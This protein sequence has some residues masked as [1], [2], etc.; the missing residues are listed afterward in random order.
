MRTSSTDPARQSASQ[1]DNVML[2]T[3]AGYVVVALMIGQ[4]YGQFGVA[5]AVASALAIIAGAAHTLARGTLL[6]RLTLATCSMALVALHIHLGGG[7]IE[8]HFGVFVTLALL[9][10]YR[11]WRPILMAAGVIAVQHV[12]FDRLQAAGWAV[13]CTPEADFLKIVLH[14]AYVV[15]QSGVEVLIA[16]RL[17]RAEQQGMELGQIVSELRRDDRIALDISN[18]PAS[19]QT[20]QRLK[21][22]LLHLNARIREVTASVSGMREA[23]AEMATGNQDLNDRTEQAAG[24]IQQISS[25]VVQL[26]ESVSRSVGSARSADEMARSAAS[27]AAKGGAVVSQ[28][29]DLMNDIQQSSRKV[30]DITGVIDGIAFQTN[31]LA[32]NAAVE[33]AR[34]GEQGRGFAVVA[35]EVRNLAH[36]AGDAAKQIRQLIAESVEKVESG[37]RLAQDAGATMNEIVASSDRVSASIGEI[38]ALTQMQGGGITQV[39][40]SLGDLD[41]MTQQNA[42]LVRQ[43]AAAARRLNEQAATLATF[44]LE[45]V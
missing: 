21:E 2:V 18:V 12:V 44:D 38:S 10:V 32:L 35:G 43:S 39:N 19:T 36:R 24:S 6:S 13:Y 40:A 22:T 41:R 30:A 29:V 26:T 15:V 34:A 9:L 42:A 1:A 31:I 33:A 3:I 8:F 45:R 20:A 11:D 4:H 16:V 17:F 5:L 28:V 25:A 7:T 27:V 14:A 23:S 37:S